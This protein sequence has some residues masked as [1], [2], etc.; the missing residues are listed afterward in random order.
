MLYPDD[1]ELMTEFTT[2]L[3]NVLSCWFAIFGKFVSCNNLRYIRLYLNITAEA[4][5][6]PVWNLHFNVQFLILFCSISNM[7]NHQVFF[8]YK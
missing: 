6:K 3:Q 8:F 2:H 7:R 1:I 5:F 4:A